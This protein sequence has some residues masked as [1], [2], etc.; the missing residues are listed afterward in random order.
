MLHQGIGGPR[1]DQSCDFIP[2]S[3]LQGYLDKTKLEQLLDAVVEKSVRHEVD[4]DHVLQHYLRPF[5][6]LLCLDKG[7]L[8]HHFYMHRSLRDASLPFGVQPDDFPHVSDRFFDKFK[9]AQWQFC[10]T[11]MHRNM[12]EHLKEEEILPFMWM[13]EL[14]HGGSAT[15]Y[16]IVVESSYN[17]LLP[18]DS[19]PAV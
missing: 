11:E 6:I 4:A 16:R 13:K 5:A 15:V 7:Y 8:I 12:N 3:K 14:G 1:N 9:R 19:Q 17:K 10:A 18:K 2:I